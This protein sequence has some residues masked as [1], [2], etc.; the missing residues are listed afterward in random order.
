M[1]QFETLQDAANANTPEGL[2]YYW[3]NV[4]HDAYFNEARL[5]Q[6]HE[7]IAYANRE[8][9]HQNGPMV[10]S[11]LDIG[12]GPGYFLSEFS[13]S[14]PEISMMGVDYAESAVK[15]AKRMKGVGAILWDV[16][17]PLLLTPPYDLAFCLQTFEHITRWDLLLKNLL[18]NTKPGGHLIITIPN[19]EFDNLPQHVNRWTFK[20]FKDI[21]QP[22]G[23]VTMRYLGKYSRILGHVRKGE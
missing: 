15:Y 14:H 4:D 21:L 13:K 12:C 17:N 3:A 11:A 5:H 23:G 6:Y 20:E 2:D 22:Y 8:V 19:G 16:T 7:V 18:M 1:S 9:I 10:L